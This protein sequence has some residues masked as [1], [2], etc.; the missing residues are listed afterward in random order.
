MRKHLF[1]KYVGADPIV[2]TTKIGG[3]MNRKRHR[4]SHGRTAFAGKYFFSKQ[5]KLEV[6][7]RLGQRA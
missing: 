6:K 4:R 7:S 5:R 2:P 1:Y 3:S